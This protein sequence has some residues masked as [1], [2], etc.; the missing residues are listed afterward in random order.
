MSKKGEGET[1]DHIEVPPLERGQGSPLQIGEDKVHCS[2]LYA[3]T[4]AMKVHVSGEGIKRVVQQPICKRLFVQHIGV[5]NSSSI[6]A[7]TDGGVVGDGVALDSLGRHLPQQPQC[8]L[9][10]AALLARQDGCAVGDG[11][12]LEALGRH[13]AQQ[14]LCLLPLAA[15]RSCQDE[16]W[17]GFSDMLSLGCWR[18][19]DTTAHTDSSPSPLSS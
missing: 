6:L 4:K 14:P 7:R 11:V 9:P 13:L 17:L 15:L 19:Q 10:P 8:L 2:P 16:L 1:C 12:A 5:T 18:Y 3:G